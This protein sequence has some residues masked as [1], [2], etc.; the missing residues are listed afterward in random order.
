MVEGENMMKEFVK[1]RWGG[2]SLGLEYKYRLIKY[3]RRLVIFDYLTGEIVK[4]VRKEKSLN[5]FFYTEKAMK[6]L[7]EINKIEPILSEEVKQEIDSTG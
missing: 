5:D 7:F 4:K 1:D 2:V 3:K 6:R